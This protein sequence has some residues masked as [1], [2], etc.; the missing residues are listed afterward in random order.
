MDDCLSNS[1]VQSRFAV[2]LF[3]VFAHVFCLCLKASMLTRW[4]V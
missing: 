3:D 1:F 4:Y 2:V